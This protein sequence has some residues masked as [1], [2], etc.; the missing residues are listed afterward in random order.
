MVAPRVMTRRRALR[1]LAVA[2]SVGVAGCGDPFAL[3]DGSFHGHYSQ[4]FEVNHFLPCG[5]RDGEQ[6]W[7]IGNI[8]TVQQY[9]SSNSLGT[10][11]VHWQGELSDEGLYGTGQER[12][13]EVTR[14]ISVRAVRGDDCD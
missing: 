13:L 14:V 3:P 4:G 10:V 12:E 11:Y 9:M 1:R 6:W 8:Q 2:V 5:A 7:I